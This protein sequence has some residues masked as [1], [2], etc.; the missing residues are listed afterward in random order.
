[1]LQWG[2]EK[3][4][5]VEIGKKHLEQTTVARCARKAAS[6]RKRSRQNSVQN[7]PIESFPALTAT[8]CVNI[9]AFCPGAIFST[10]IQKKLIVT[11]LFAPKFCAE[12]SD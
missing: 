4:F 7:R 12:L 11:K 10:P 5:E 6:S 2:R 9:S 1:M 8:T 3:Y